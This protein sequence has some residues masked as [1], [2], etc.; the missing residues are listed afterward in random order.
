MFYACGSKPSAPPA[1]TAPKRVVQNVN[2]ALPEAQIETAEE[3]P[4]ELK[5]YVYSRRGRRDPFS[6]LIV[7]SQNKKKDDSKLGTLEGYDLGEFMLG[8]IAN[9]ENSYFALLV[10]PDNRS[11]TVEKGTILGLNRG[12]IKRI[13]SN[14]VVMVEY[15]KDYK[16]DLKPRELTLELHK[17]EGK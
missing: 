14:K 15:I 2:N 7:I 8:A 12:K 1:K 4:D 16:G 3:K 11:F 10:A 5:G 17:G 9:K 6:S 13:T